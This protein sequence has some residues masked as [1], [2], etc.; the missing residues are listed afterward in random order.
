MNPN[1]PCESEDPVQR[2]NIFARS[3]KICRKFW[4]EKSLFSLSCGLWNHYIFN[5]KSKSSLCIL[6]EEATKSRSRASI[7]EASVTKDKDKKGKESQSSK[8]RTSAKTKARD[9]P[10]LHV[11]STS[12]CTEQDQHQANLELKRTQR[13]ESHKEHVFLVCM[14]MSLLL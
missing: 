5:L 8:R 7:K 3:S 6:K 2:S 10:R 14:I 11:A 13:Q 12:D 1:K 4:M 9:S